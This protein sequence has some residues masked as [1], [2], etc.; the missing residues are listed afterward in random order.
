MLALCSTFDHL[1]TDLP[2]LSRYI[3]GV[4]HDHSDG[5]IMAS[6]PEGKGTGLVVGRFTCFVCGSFD[7]FP[8]YGSVCTLLIRL[9]TSKGL[10]ERLFQRGF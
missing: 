1:D 8:R 10:I 2:C 5:N 7:V 9:H 3:S 6:L 4:V